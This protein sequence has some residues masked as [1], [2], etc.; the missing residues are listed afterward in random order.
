MVKMIFFKSLCKSH[1]RPCF[2]CC[3]GFELGVKVAVFS[4]L[5][6]FGAFWRDHLEPDLKK[7][8]HGTQ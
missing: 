2:F 4:K 7:I 1:L 3:C 8:V 6:V 5:K